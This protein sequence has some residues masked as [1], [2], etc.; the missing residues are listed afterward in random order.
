MKKHGGQVTWAI[1]KQ[2]QFKGQE[3]DDDDWMA[4]VQ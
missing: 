1:Y 2:Q 4:V 3:D